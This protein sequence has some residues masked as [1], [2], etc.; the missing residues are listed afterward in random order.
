MSAAHP[1]APRPARVVAA[2]REAHDVVTLTIEAP[3]HAPSPGQFNMLYA[4]GVGEAPISTSGDPGAD[5][6]LVHTIKAVGAVTRALCALEPDSPVGLR[7]PF[8]T[9]WPLPDA[10]GSDLLIVAGGLGL[11][12]LRPVLYHALSHRADYGLVTIVAGARTPADLLYQDELEAWATRG[13][14]TVVR[15]VDRATTSWEGRV[16]VVPAVLADCP[17]TDRTVAFVC[18]P[19]VMMRY[20]VRELTRRAL[21]LARIYVS[22]ERNMKCAIGL[23][24]HCQFGPSFVCKDGPVYRADRVQNL[25]SIAEI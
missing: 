3:L 20:A 16:G 7:G 15:T 19:E 25:L 5:G 24:G 22:L 9:A 8:G 18:G 1:L 10:R 23:C 21:P 2:R 12:P 17:L 13:D 6:Q 4:F 14:L 11:A